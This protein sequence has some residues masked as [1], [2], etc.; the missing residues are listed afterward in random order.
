MKISGFTDEVSSSLDEQ[1]AV[2]HGLGR[3]YMCPRGINGK[4]ISDYT[5]QEFES[6]IKPVLQREKISFSSIGSPIG[7]IGLYDDKAYA[8]QCEQLAE[9]VKIARS[10]G[11]GYIRIFSFFVEPDGNYD[12]YF[13]VAVKKLKGFLDIAKGSGVKLMHENEKRIFGD[14]PERVK[15]LYDAIGDPDFVLCYD[16]S[17]YI[18]CGCDPWKA[19]EA[20]R[21]Y[22]VYYHMKDCTEGVEVPL[23]TGQG[24][25]KDIIGDLAARG[26]DGFLTLEPHTFKYALLKIP[27]YLLPPVGKIAKLRRIYRQVDAH[28]GVGAFQ[29]VGRKEV[30]IRQHDNLVAMLKEAGVS[31]E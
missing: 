8:R 20:L 5:A 24:R 10:M 25:I 26:Y 18:Q 30:Y 28:M 13:P 14:V 2:L 19:Y 12:E 3:H 29:R 9:L 6:E 27:V 23:G 4:N 11:C 7:K 21:D 22:T 15:A 16:A 31:Y 1:I 17:N